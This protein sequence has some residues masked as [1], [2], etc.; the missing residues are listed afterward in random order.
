MDFLEITQLSPP[1]SYKISCKPKASD[2]LTLISSIIAARGVGMED[3]RV[4]S[5]ILWCQVLLLTPISSA[6]SSL[7]ILLSWSL[8]TL[9]FK[10]LLR[11]AQGGLYLS[12]Q[13][14]RLAGGSHHEFE[15]TLA[16]PSEFHTGWCYKV[17]PRLKTKSITGALKYQSA[18][19]FSLWEKK[20]EED[21]P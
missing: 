10:I 15:A 7:C 17:R 20:A 3:R 5:F 18:Q 2:A 1:S 12:T 8:P 9:I 16:L 14:F 13:A 19:S 6:R 4:I 11:A 21:S